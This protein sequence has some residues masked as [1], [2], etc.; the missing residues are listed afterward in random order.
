MGLGVQGFLGLWCR[1]RA[2]SSLRGLKVRIP[3]RDS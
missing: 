3:Y 1:L 2:K